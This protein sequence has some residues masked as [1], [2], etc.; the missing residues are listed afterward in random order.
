MATESK[1][2]K[3][4]LCGAEYTKN[5]MTKHL[6]ACL[7]KRLDKLSEQ[8]ESKQKS[9]FHILVSGYHSP[10]YWIHLKIDNNSRL[11]DLDNFL[12]DIWLECCGHL[13]AFRYQR[14]EVKMTQKVKDVFYPQ[15][16][17]M[18]EY[19]FG[20]TT[21]LLVKVVGEYQGIL[22]DNDKPIQ[23]LVRNEPPEILCD[24]CGTLPATD[25]CTEH[26]W[27]EGGWLCESCAKNHE[28]D[29]EMFLPV[30][31]SPRVGVCG[32]TG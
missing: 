29:E 19:D 1:K 9:F 10:E 17:L 18:Y 12:R 8:K 22:K 5:G 21:T 13:S 23:I 24:K 11:K 6:Q 16:G 26:Q 2:A 28:C 27:Y 25:I 31:N 14:E 15:M 7:S 20:S 3:C 4:S 32:Y 30:V